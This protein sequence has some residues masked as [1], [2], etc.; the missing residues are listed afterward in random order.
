MGSRVRRFTWA[1]RSRAKS[2]VSVQLL[3]MGPQTPSGPQ[4]L[5]TVPVL[6]P[7]HGA[8]CPTHHPASC[9]PVPQRLDA[10]HSV[11]IHSETSP[12]ERPHPHCPGATTDPTRS[13]CGCLPGLICRPG[14]AWTPSLAAAG[15]SGG[16]S[17]RD[18]RWRGSPQAC[19]SKASS[20][21][22][23]PLGHRPRPSGR[24]AQGH[25]HARAGLPQHSPR[26][27]PLTPVPR[28]QDGPNQSQ[29]GARPRGAGQRRCARAGE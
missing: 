18:R 20:L 7:G 27:I 10:P 25:M 11:T 19:K 6:S 9:L 22:C 26:D 5:F 21:S 1:L 8:S 4:G 29:E 24:A 16:A 17:F 23:W 14:P 28:A 2:P 12:A 15:A 13:P 3:W